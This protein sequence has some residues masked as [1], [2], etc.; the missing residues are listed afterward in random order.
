[1]PDPSRPHLLL[2]TPLGLVRYD[3]L[4][5]AAFVGPAARGGV[6]ASDAP[7]PKAR[8]ALTREGGSFRVRALPGEPP[9]SV[10]GRDVET[11]LLSDGDRLAL[12]ADVVLFRGAAPAPAALPA[13]VR[14]ERRP[15]DGD[16]GAARK[17]PLPAVFSLAGALLVLFAAYRAVRM[18]DQPSPRRVPSTPVVSE[19]DVRVPREEERAAQALADARA[20]EAE[21][22]E[23]VAGAVSRWRAVAREHAG[24]PDAVAAA[25]R[26]AELWPRAGARAW[27]T[28]KAT[29]ESFA[30]DRR[31]AR[32]LEV[33]REHEA[34]YAGTESGDAA[35]ALAAKV[36]ADARAA[37]DALR[38]RVAPL[39]AS[40]PAT[41]Y[42]MLTSSPPDL[43]ADLEAELA[44]LMA[45][46][47]ETWAASQ[48]EPSRPPER[49]PA[50]SEPTTAGAPAPGTPPPGTPTP[51]APPGPAAPSLA[52]EEAAKEAWRAARAHLLA[53][54]W[55]EALAA[56]DALLSAHGTTATV[57]SRRQVVE[58]GRRAADAGVR[59][60]PALLRRPSVWKDG[61]LAVEYLFDD[62][63]EIE[64]DFAV[65]QPF[66]GNYER[67]AEHGDGM[68]LLTGST[69][70]LH[71]VVYEPD[72]SLEVD[73][74][75]DDPR[76]FGLYALQEAKPYR[77]VAL[78]AW[79]TQKKLKKGAAARVLAGH[80]LWLLGEGAWS[81]TDPDEMGF[82][83]LDQ[84]S[85][86][87]LEPGKRTRLALEVRGGRAEGRV[88]VGEAQSTLAAAVKGDDGG[89]IGALRVGAHA[90]TSVVGVD[91]LKIEGKVDMAWFSRRLAE[92]AALDVGP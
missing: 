42:R 57:S 69:A 74:Y 71:E 26:V 40:D 43:P 18:L 37:L 58:A 31:F 44:T 90:F 2:P 38:D 86:P 34:R 59:G 82:V 88:R 52:G 20:Y 79:N 64:A 61:R 70:I 55:P 39:F 45:R 49:E 15:D 75:S 51:P 92:L 17:S 48:P 7:F 62:P 29:A 91:R 73:V 36:R 56:Y 4:D 32:A 67:R 87:P 41:A 12:G 68:A 6:T 35:R 78:D 33:L 81:A 50:P 76:D 3:L 77:A 89:A 66:P 13:P 1:M 63:G 21:H 10:S 19:P 28:A 60:P 8:L 54:R 23:D 30:R 25:E 27:E 47:R 16:V 83:F 53:K 24:T 5:D 11:A 65:E 72:V 22:P 46:A 9:P 14:A 80:V 85:G 84:E